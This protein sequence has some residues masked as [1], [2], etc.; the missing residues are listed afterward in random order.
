MWKVAFGFDKGVVGSVPTGGKKAKDHH[1][2]IAIKLFLDPDE[3]FGAFTD[4]DLEKLD[5]V[6]KNRINAYV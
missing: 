4:T 3:P 6:V 2:A 5:D 1:R